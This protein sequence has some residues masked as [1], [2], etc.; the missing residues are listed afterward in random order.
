MNDCY[1]PPADR[2]TLQCA[3]TQSRRNGA[4]QR[5][6]ILQ[7]AFAFAGDERGEIAP[8]TSFLMTTLSISIPMGYMFLRIYFSMCD[9]GRQ[10]NLLIGLF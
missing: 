1:Q 7:L 6:H 2:N 9:A 3:G 5:S 8:V 10:A 4:A